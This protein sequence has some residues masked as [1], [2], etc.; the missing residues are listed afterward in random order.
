MEIETSNRFGQQ[1][2]QYSSWGPGRAIYLVLS[3]DAYKDDE[4]CESKLFVKLSSRIHVATQYQHDLNSNC[5]RNLKTNSPATSTDIRP[6]CSRASKFQF[7]QCLWPG[8]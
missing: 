6:A 3:Q 1:H 7:E 2:R 4:G 5:R 8:E